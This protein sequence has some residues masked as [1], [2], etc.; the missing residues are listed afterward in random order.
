MGDAREAGN[1][2]YGVKFRGPNG[3]VFDVSAI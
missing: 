3:V 2:F 1:S